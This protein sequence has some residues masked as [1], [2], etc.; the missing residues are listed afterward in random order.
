MVPDNIVHSS[1]RR[2]QESSEYLDN[3]SYCFI[4]QLYSDVVQS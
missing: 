2:I 4:V 1:I 3:K